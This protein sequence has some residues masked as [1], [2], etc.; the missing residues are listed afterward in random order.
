MDF[1]AAYFP[2]KTLPHIEN[3]LTQD[4]LKKLKKMI[5]ANASLVV[6]DLGGSSHGHLGLVIPESK[7][8]K[9]TGSIHKKLQHPGELKINETTNL[10]DIII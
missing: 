8:I 9:I 1:V 3:R 10:Q 5:K 6:S 2:F 4:S 7:Y